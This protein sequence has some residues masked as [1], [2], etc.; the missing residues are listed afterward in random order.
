MCASECCG[1]SGDNQQNATD[2]HGR[3]VSKGDGEPWKGE[4]A[5][6]GRGQT[7]G[8][9]KVP[10]KLQ[11]GMSSNLYLSRRFN[12]IKADTVTLRTS[13]EQMLSRS[14]TKE[15]FKT[16]IKSQISARSN[17]FR[18]FTFGS[19]CRSG[20]RIVFQRRIPEN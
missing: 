6:R 18:P 4:S 8:R 11:T 12:R 17:C 2:Q 13:V 16:L 1:R 19:R 7:D 10:L 20:Y 5:R 3:E 14:R 9:G 15:D